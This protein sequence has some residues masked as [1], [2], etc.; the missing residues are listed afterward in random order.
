[1]IGNIAGATPPT[2][3]ERATESSL[4]IAHKLMSKGQAARSTYPL[5]CASVTPG[6]IPSYQVLAV[7]SIA[8]RMAPNV[9]AFSVMATACGIYR[10]QLTHMGECMSATFPNGSAVPLQLFTPEGVG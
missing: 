2:L 1:M 7:P 3:P 8:F 10:L 5:L 9:P 4:Y 6:A